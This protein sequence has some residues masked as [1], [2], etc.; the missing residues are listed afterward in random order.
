MGGAPVQSGAT[1]VGPNST[2][3][4]DQEA[5]PK[6]SRG[7]VG[8]SAIM[9]KEDR[10]IAPVAEKRTALVPDCCRGLHPTRSLPVEFT[11]RLQVAVVSL[12]KKFDANVCRHF[13][14]G[15]CRL[16]LLTRIQRRSVVTQASAPGRTF[17]RTVGENKGPGRLVQTDHVRLTTGLFHR[18][19]RLDL[20]SVRIQ[21]SS[22]VAPLNALMA[23]RMVRKPLAELFKKAFVF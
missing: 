16:V 21:P 3:G 14:S 4:L 2:Q 7:V 17:R 8:L 20:F 1:H 22:D 19:Q 13:H 6:T 10:P 15:T 5:S 18:C 12:S 11:E 23:V 9:I